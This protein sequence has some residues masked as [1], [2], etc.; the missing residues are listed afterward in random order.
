M[1]AFLLLSKFY[2]NEHS[3]KEIFYSIYIWLV[4]GGAEGEHYGEFSFAWLVIIVGTVYISII[5][6][7]IVIAYL[8][9]VFSRLEEEQNISLV[10]EKASMILDFEAIIYFF[11]FVLTCKHKKIDKIDKYHDQVHKELVEKDSLY[12]NVSQMLTERI[13]S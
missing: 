3:F 13:I 2:D 10:R 6:M 9:N 1:I 12:N 4:L 7:N 8:S 5:L 11:K